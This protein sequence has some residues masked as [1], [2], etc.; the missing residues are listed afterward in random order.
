MFHRIVVSDNRSDRPLLHFA[1]KKL[2]DL[3]A[4]SDAPQGSVESQH[5]SPWTRRLHFLR[6]L[7]ADKEIHAQL[8]PYMERI[9]LTC[10]KYLESEIWS[11][12]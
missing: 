6:A 4:T 3:L 12:R 2:L 7:V 1:V 5:D 8:L 10:F 9:S 11:I